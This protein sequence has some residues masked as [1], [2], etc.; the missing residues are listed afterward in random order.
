MNIIV[1][2]GQNYRESDEQKAIFL[3]HFGAGFLVWFIYILGLGI[4][5]SFV[6]ALWRFKMILGKL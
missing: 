6:S 1:F 2:I 4:I 5:A 3:A